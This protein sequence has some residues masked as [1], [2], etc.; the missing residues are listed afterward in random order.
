MKHTSER[1]WRI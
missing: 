1:K